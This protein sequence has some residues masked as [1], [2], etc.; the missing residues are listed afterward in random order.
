MIILID[1]RQKVIII[2]NSNHSK[3][4]KFF[5]A[6]LQ[7]LRCNDFVSMASLKWPY[8]NGF[9]FPVCIFFSNKFII[10]LDNGLY[11]KILTIVSDFC[12]KESGTLAART[13][14]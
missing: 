7:R 2:L 1:F 13:F 14:S 12:A 11:R 10:F 6:S 4:K 5:M 8:R 9:R 3:Q